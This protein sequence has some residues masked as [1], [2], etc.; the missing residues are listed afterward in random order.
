MFYNQAKKEFINRLK[1]AEN[2]Y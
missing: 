1:A 2:R